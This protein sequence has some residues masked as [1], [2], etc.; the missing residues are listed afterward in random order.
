MADGRKK[1]PPISVYPSRATTEAARRDAVAAFEA[2]GST[3]HSP[4]REMLAFIVQHCE[5]NG[6]GYRINAMPAVGY[7]IEKWQPTFLNA[8][9]G[10][11]QEDDR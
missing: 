7:T 5:E 8:M 6:I 4:R 9:D 2:A 10:N 1:V 3:S 11:A